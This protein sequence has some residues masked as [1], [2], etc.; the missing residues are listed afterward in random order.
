MRLKNQ[1]NSKL[2]KTYKN[3]SLINAAKTRDFKKVK[4]FYKKYINY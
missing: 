4:F 2:K 3:N 1:K